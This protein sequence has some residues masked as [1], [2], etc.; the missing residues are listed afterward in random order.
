MIGIWPSENKYVHELEGQIPNKKIFRVQ[1]KLCPWL[2]SAGKKLFYYCVER[3]HTDVKNTKSG[4]GTRINRDTYMEKY[5]KGTRE[6]SAKIG[7]QYR[8]FSSAR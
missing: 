6:K 8:H 5:G 4:R 7:A 2:P 3:V 1:T